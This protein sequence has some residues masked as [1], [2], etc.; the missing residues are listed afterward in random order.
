[1][2]KIAFSIFIS[3]FLSFLIICAWNIGVMSL[4]PELGFMDFRLD[5]SSVFVVFFALYRRGNWLPW[6]VLYVE[7]V[8][9]LFS[10]TGWGHNVIAG[11]VILMLARALKE[12]INIKHI[13]ASILF[14]EA[15]LIIRYCVLSL[16]WAAKME[17]MS[18]WPEMMIDYLPQSFF[19]TLVALPLFKVLD[20]V[21]PSKSLDAD[22]ELGHV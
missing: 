17:A 4:I 19:M 8:Q 3:G 16:F 21:W 7:F 2:K 15:M 9:S 5:I 13:F 22:M 10:V 6:A 20:K 12:F 11:L 18:S 14:I 1:M